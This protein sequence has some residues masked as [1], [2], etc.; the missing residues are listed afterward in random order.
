MNHKKFLIGRPDSNIV[1]QFSSLPKE[2][3]VKY[4]CMGNIDCSAF[5]VCTEID[6]SMLLL[7]HGHVIVDSVSVKKF[8]NGYE[9]STHGA[10]PFW[11]TSN[12]QL[13]YIYKS[14]MLMAK[15]THRIEIQVTV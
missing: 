9:L 14:A 2:V 15:K 6:A 13:M 10:D 4:A 3:S 5:V 7:V 8:M 1:I 11:L 12:V